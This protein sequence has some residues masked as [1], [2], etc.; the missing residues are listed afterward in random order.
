MSRTSWLAG[1]VAL[2]IALMIGFYALALSVSGGLLW[3]A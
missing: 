3:L 2:A 1:R